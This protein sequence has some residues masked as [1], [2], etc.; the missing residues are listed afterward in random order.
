LKGTSS[1]H[2]LASARCVPWWS[3]GGLRT[4]LTTC[5]RGGCSLVSSCQFQ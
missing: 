5:R 2:R 3:R 4:V 1:R